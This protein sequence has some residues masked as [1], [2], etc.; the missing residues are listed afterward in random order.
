[1]S[2]FASLPFGPKN[3]ATRPFHSTWPGC[4]QQFN[5]SDA[6]GQLVLVPL[7]APRRRVQRPMAENLG[8][9]RVVVLKRLRFSEERAMHIAS[10]STSGP[11]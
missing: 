5:C 2:T 4:P 1:M 3:I 11:E 7:H 6:S 8:L 10:P 9:V